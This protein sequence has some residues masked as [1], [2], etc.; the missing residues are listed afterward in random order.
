MQ[1]VQLPEWIQY[2]AGFV[3][4]VVTGT[5]AR[6]GLISAKSTPAAAPVAVSES[7]TIVVLDPKTIKALSGVLD[8]LTQSLEDMHRDRLEC[9]KKSREELAELRTDIRA[10]T[11]QIERAVEHIKQ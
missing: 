5:A 11:R 10:L 4:L 6:M 7:E 1:T 9:S 8:E 3:I 2:V